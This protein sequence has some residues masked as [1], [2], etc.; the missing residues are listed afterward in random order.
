MSFR[1]ESDIN[2]SEISRRGT[3]S[4]D[5]TDAFAL[6]VAT[7][8]GAGH[9]PLAPG[10][11]GTL[12]G[13]PV[14]LVLRAQPF[15]LFLLSLAG[16]T[17]LGV[18]ASDRAEALL[19]RRDPPA[20]VIDEVV[21]FAVTMAGVELGLLSLGVGFVLFRVLDNVKLPPARWVERR[22]SGGLGIVADDVAAGLYANVCLRAF[23]GILS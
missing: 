12:L 6:A 1:E 15:G 14:C 23:L 2:E 20:V 5:P 22:L 13:I 11:I 4:R 21:G 7:L 17:A 3:P 18:W 16:L 9:F 19:G 8:V 10:T